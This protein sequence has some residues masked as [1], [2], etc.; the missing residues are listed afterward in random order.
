[1]NIRVIRICGAW[2][3]RVGVWLQY[4]LIEHVLPRQKLGD[5]VDFVCPSIAQHSGIDTAFER[6]CAI[7][8][9][10]GGGRIRDGSVPVVGGL[11][12]G[13]ED[14]GVALEVSTHA[15][16]ESGLVGWRNNGSYF[17][18]GTV[19]PVRKGDDSIS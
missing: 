7:R 1:M 19:V 5:R 6:I 2:C 16:D 4:V 12:V 10:L 15:I 18:G 17:N 9:E 13:V 14:D 11:L 8:V 3:S